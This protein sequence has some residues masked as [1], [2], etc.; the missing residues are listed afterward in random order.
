MTN[1]KLP[2]SVFIIAQ[3]EADRIGTTISSV[4]S[5]ADEIIVIDSGSADDTMEV[6]EKL[7]ARAIFN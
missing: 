5:F 6:A 7:G 4:Q 1:V 2:I 3:N